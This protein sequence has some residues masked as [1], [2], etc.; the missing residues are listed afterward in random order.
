MYAFQIKVIDINKQEI[1]ILVISF[2]E[3]INILRVELSKTV[4]SRVI[5]YRELA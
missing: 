5:F 1:H 2:I 4:L 3:F